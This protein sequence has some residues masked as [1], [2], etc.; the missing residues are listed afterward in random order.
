MGEHA[1]DLASGIITKVSVAE[2]ECEKV[3]RELKLEKQWGLRWQI[4]V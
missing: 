2:E 3:S 4:G 1:G